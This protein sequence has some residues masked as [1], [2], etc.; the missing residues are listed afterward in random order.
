MG[1]IIP[2]LKLYPCIQARE[3]NYCCAFRGCP[4]L[5]YPHSLYHAVLIVLWYAKIPPDRFVSTGIPRVDL[6]IVWDMFR[7]RARV[8]YRA[9]KRP[10]K[11]LFIQPIELA[12]PFEQ[13]NNMTPNDLGRV[14]EKRTS[15]GQIRLSRFPL[16]GEYTGKGPSQGNRG[17]P[18]V[19]CVQRQTQARV[20]NT[21]SM[22]P[23][24]AAIGVPKR[25]EICCNAHS[26]L[27]RYPRRLYRQVPPIT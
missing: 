17:W 11:G 18:Q 15:Q 3:S 22:P 4:T 5:S 21:D 27:P 2:A 13:S 9:P 1:V 14:N 8:C 12:R 6:E 24:I 10:L 16:L 25:L 19:N 20:L 23:H 26:Y 7:V